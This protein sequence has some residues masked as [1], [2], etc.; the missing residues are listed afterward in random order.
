MFEFSELLCLKLYWI[1]QFQ[2]G[3]LTINP[4]TH[5]HNIPSKSNET[6]VEKYR[7][8]LHKIS[9]ALGSENANISNDIEQLI[10]FQLKLEKV[11]QMVINDTSS[12]METLGSFSAETNVDW[13]SIMN[14]I[15]T[16]FNSNAPKY[17][18]ETKTSAK[19][20]YISLVIQTINTTPIEVLQNFY[21]IAILQNYGPLTTKTTRELLIDFNIEYHLFSLTT[22]CPFLLSEWPLITGRVYV[23]AYFSI[24]EK[25][26]A[27]N[28]VN[29]I[30]SSFRTNIQTNN[31]LDS[32]TRKHAIEKLDAMKHMV[33]FDEW[34]L[35]D[36]LVD[37]HSGVLQANETYQKGKFL[38]TYISFRVRDSKVELETGHREPDS[39]LK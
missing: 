13:L 25:A 35:S 7:Q 16:K 30:R 29:E 19:L 12:K 4:A 1:I 37:K 34:I 23:D 22:F 17:T 18:M 10:H 24:E 11:Y 27:T 36:E 15:L 2:P 31:W 33:G 14:Q 38:E 8:F 5:P 28:M 3:P 9:A 21:G 26:K 39:K 32:E 20:K 6:D